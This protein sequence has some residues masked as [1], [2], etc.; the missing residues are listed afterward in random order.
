MEALGDA[1]LHML[2]K[3]GDGVSVERIQFA[4]AI[5]NVPARRPVCLDENWRLQGGPYAVSRGSSSLRKRRTSSA[6]S[7]L[8]PEPVGDDGVSEDM[9]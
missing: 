3:E 2:P 4:R 7:G 9:K 8:L 6:G 5:E 1:H